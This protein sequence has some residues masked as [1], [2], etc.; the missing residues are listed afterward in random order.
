MKFKRIPQ[1]TTWIQSLDAILYL[2]LRIRIGKHTYEAEVVLVQK[3][4]IHNEGAEQMLLL[5]VRTW[6]RI[7]EMPQGV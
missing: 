6:R 1:N 4:G 7:A 3:G 5:Y 2:H